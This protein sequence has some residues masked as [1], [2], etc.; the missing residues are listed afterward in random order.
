MNPWI[1]DLSTSDR[2]RYL[3]LADCIAADIQGG[4]L[5]PGDRLPPQ[6]KLAEQLGVDFTTVARGY[7][8]AQR[9]GLVESRGSQGTFVL[10]STRARAA[11]TA[12]SRQWP[13]T[14]DL[15]MNLPPEPDDPDLV[16][17][18]QAGLEAVGHDLVP[19]LRYQGFGGAPA[20]KE[21][22][23]QWLARRGLHPA[24][25]RI[26]ITPGAQPA[27]FGILNVV[28][29]PG[30]VILC[31][32][33]TYAGLRS[34]V[35]HLG[36]ILVG[37]PMDGEGIMPDAF[38]AACAEFSPKALYLNPTLQNPTTITTSP[39]RREAIVAIARQFGVPIIE[40]DAYGAIPTDGP[41]PLAAL[42]PDTTWYVAPLAKCMGAGLRVAYVAVPDMQSGWAFAAAVRCV[43]VMASPLT[44]SLATRWI[45]DGTADAILRFIRTESAARQAIARQVLPPGS[46][47]SDPSSFHIWLSLHDG[48]T[49]STFT[50]H[51]RATGL[52]VVPSDAFATD[53][54]PP[55]AVRV[56]LGGPLARAEIQSALEFA[57][58]ALR[59]RPA[60]ATSFL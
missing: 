6:R 14:I 51:M 4:K 23:A 5:L 52:G 15:L 11:A 44:V 53:D 60:I 3:A 41:K 24:R 59:E 30:Q 56:G 55:E 39:A 7:V 26:F 31:E 35:A 47:R 8:E 49:R 29:K 20:D 37:L 22:A 58:H 57:A 36:M 13:S 1:P 21:V 43:T 50:G 28:A 2:P 34:A 38:V 16:A 25:E 32:H 19:L 42:A 40:D 18:M 9:R 10:A 45:Q 27:L 17:R 33:L 54:A 12:P 46:F 48:W